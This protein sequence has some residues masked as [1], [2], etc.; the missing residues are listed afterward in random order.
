MLPLAIL[1]AQSDQDL[2]HVRALFLEYAASLPFDLSFQDF[3]RE[4]EGLPGKYRPPTGQLLLARVGENVAGCVAVCMLS[5]EICEMKRL[6]VRPSHRG[7]G[8]GR[9]LAESAVA[10]AREIGYQRMRL[11]TVPSMTAALSL[12]RSLGFEETDPY[13]HN[14]VPGAVFLELVLSD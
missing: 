14:P 3:D 12:Y 5:R 9:R 4:L 8:V 10:N 11:D 13:R 6:Y 2:L 1:P 7:K